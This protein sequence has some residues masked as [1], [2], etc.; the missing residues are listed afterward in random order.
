MPAGAESWNKLQSAHFLIVGDV[1]HGRLTAIARTLEDF[2]LAA[3]RVLGDL[4]VEAARPL[5]VV[6]INP[7][8]MLDYAP[9]ASNNVA[10][11]YRRTAEHDYIVMGTNTFGASD[12]QVV[13][14]EYQHLITHENFP[15]TPGWV[16][17]GLAE[18][19]STFEE[20]DGGTRYKIGLPLGH[21]LATLQRNGPYP[22][23]QFLQDDGRSMAIDERFRV[24]IYYAQSWALI[25]F[26][27]LGDGGKWTKTFGPFVDALV[28]G[29]AVETAFRRTVSPDVNEFEARFKA[30]LAGRRFNYATFTPRSGGPSARAVETG[31]LSEAETETLK[32]TLSNDATKADA[33]LAL[34]LKADPGYRPARAMRAARLLQQHQIG[35]AADELAAIAL[36]DSGSVH[37]CSLASL[38]SNLTRRFAQSLKIC[39][40]V[41]GSVTMAFDRAVALDALGQGTEA[42]RLFESVA[43]A[44]ADA[45]RDLSD[46]PWWYLEEGQ[47]AAAAR[48]ADIVNT[49]RTGN[50]DVV[51]YTRFVRAVSMCLEDKCDEARAA[52]KASEVPSG[53][54]AWAQQVFRYLIGDV[55]GAA[56]MK[57]ATT[58]AQETEARTYIALNLLAQRRTADAVTH[59]QW[60]ADRGSRT[61]TEYYVAVSHLTRIAKSAPVQ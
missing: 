54:S 36:A 18:F 3:D 47:Y 16:D 22:L 56:L 40:D 42:L 25:H 49:L 31:R 12:F 35:Q 61:V 21:H 48:A 46:R 58:P 8:K 45:L 4:A 2:R 10:A 13:L 52:L 7:T 24:G 55:D 17:E 38:T 41:R 39:P 14:H 19:Y 57:G 60:V 51:A 32:A 30:Y 53:A 50:V 28:A 29:E 33:S 9:G 44:P 59:L 43:R 15:V 23:L 20:A 5:T 11:F 1:P 37:T 26:F 6:V 27:M 34:A